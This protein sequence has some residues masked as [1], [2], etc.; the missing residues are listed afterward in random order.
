MNL[1]LCGLFVFLLENCLFHDARTEVD[2]FFDDEDKP[3]KRADIR[4]H[5]I[6]AFGEGRFMK[7][8][9]HIDEDRTHFDMYAELFKQLGS[10]YLIMNIRMRAK[11]EGKDSFVKLFEWKGL[12]FCGF[13]TEY[14]TNPMMQN[15]LKK[16]MQLSDV[17][18]CP[19][20]VG[21]YSVT[22]V[23]VVDNVHAENFQNG[24]YKLFFEIIE[25][26]GETP[27]L[28]AFQVTTIIRI[29]DI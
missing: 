11:P 14:N 24:T 10:N 2:V 17:I 20:R 1:L 6:N 8:K 15:F 25:E 13:L 18:A 21:N 4:I 23:S 26:T 19:V 28:F 12:D 9:T 16:S 7:V 27:K 3:T 5:H 29:F 22:N